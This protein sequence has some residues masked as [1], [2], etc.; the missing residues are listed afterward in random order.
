MLLAYEDSPYPIGIAVS[1]W[2]T[3][4]HLRM[5][6]IFPIFHRGKFFLDIDC[7]VEEDSTLTIIKPQT[8][9]WQDLTDKP[10]TG[11]GKHPKGYPIDDETARNLYLV[12]DDGTP[13]HPELSEKLY[14]KYSDLIS[15]YTPTARAYLEKEYD[16]IIGQARDKRWD[17][18]L[19]TRATVDFPYK[20][21]T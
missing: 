4:K 3:D 21:K 17:T 20:D 11:F 19:I 2:E 10:T 12:W 7:F 1:S 9:D 13:V 6:V 16:K 18:N 5:F 15:H 8:K 14:R